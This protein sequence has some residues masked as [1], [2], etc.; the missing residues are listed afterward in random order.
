MKS[1]AIIA[2]VILLACATPLILKIIYDLNKEEDKPD[3]NSVKM[4]EMMQKFK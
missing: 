4:Q 2:L 1:G 3:A